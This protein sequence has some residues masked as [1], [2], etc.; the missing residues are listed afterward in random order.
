MRKRAGEGESQ[1][2]RCSSRK[3]RPEKRANGDK[4]NDSGGK[5]RRGE[6]S[7]ERSKVTKTRG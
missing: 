4:Q 6:E 2:P 5:E 1:R 3:K 7:F